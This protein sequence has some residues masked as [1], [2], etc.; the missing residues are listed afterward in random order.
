[1]ISAGFKVSDCGNDECKNV[2]RAVE[3]ACDSPP[4]GEASNPKSAKD[5]CIDKYVTNPNPNYSASDPVYTS[6]LVTPEQYQ[7]MEDAKKG[8]GP[9]AK[10]GGGAPQTPPGGPATSTAAT[11]AGTIAPTGAVEADKAPFLIAGVAKAHLT[12]GYGSLGVSHEV[13]DAQTAE[14]G[15]PGFAGKIGVT[16]APGIEKLTRLHIMPYFDYRLYNNQSVTNADGLQT[17]EGYSHAKSVGI[18]LN[19]ERPGWLLGIH[20]AYSYLSASKMYWRG[21][22]NQVAT[23]VDSDGNFQTKDNPF[24]GSGFT[25]GVQGSWMFSP[26]VGLNAFADYMQTKDKD[27]M[28]GNFSQVGTMNIYTFGLGFVGILPFYNEQSA[29]METCEGAHIMMGAC[30]KKEDSKP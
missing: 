11:G 18:E 22:G 16:F 30:I 23:S 9:W 6:A 10:Q 19:V 27:H 17:K 4:P 5:Q 25:F 1:M 20:G 3:A 12:L 14:L 13:P 26:Y 8:Q 24:S 2:F 7:N 21:E 15:I 29:P 28:L